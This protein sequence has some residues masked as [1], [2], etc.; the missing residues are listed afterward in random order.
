MS[1]PAAA[2]ARAGAPAPAPF[3]APALLFLAALL[4]SAVT[5]RRTL[6]PFDEGLCYRPRR[7]SRTAVAVRRLR[8][9]VRTGQPLLNALVFELTEP[10][11]L[12]WRIVRA[13][14][15][16]GVAVLVWWLVREQGAGDRWALAGG[17]AAALTMAQPTTAKPFPVALLCALAALACAAR[18]RAVPAGL[19]VAA[20]GFW[21]ADV[22]VAAALAVVATLAIRGAG[23]RGVLRAVAVGAGATVFLLAPFAIAAGPGD[24]V[25]ALVLDSTRD[26][27]AW[28]LPFP[29]V[30]DGPLRAGH[31]LEDGKDLL[32]HELPLIGIFGLVLATAVTLRG[33]SLQRHHDRGGTDLIAA[34][35]F[36]SGCW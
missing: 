21:R 22:G 34:P 11:V 3:L 33:L 36:P 27:A 9:G 4:I 24:L 16:A 31:L 19:L 17:A 14:A 15:D 10:T 35:P 25:D 5:L 18:G 13:V 30:Y 12:A 28:R 6:D 7:G 2:A 32:T 8:L 20:A 23:R 26:G 1:T 29:F